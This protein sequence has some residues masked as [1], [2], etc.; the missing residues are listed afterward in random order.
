MILLSGLN[1]IPLLTPTS[2]KINSRFPSGS[3]LKRCPRGSASADRGTER[4]R[5]PGCAYRK[6][7]P[8]YP[9]SLCPI[10]PT[11]RFPHA[12]THHVNFRTDSKLLKDS[13]KTPLG[14]RRGIVEPMHPVLARLKVLGRDLERLVPGKG[15][16]SSMG[17]SP[18]REWSGRWGG[19][20]EEGEMFQM[21]ADELGRRDATQVL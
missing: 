1:P 15:P 12:E 3:Y 4:E 13:P 20:G 16:R 18:V 6:R 19:C 21:R 8:L 17:N 5:D 14:I 7:C 2:S 9:A 10:V 11:L